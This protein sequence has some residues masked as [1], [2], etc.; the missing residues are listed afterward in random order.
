MHSPVRARGFTLIELLVG[1][2]VGAVVLLGISM[3]FI[4]QAQQYQSHASR[5]GIQA[6]A[7]QALAFMERK[8]RA[9]GYGVHPD[10]AVLAYDSY[11]VV[12]DTAAAGYPDAVVVH[13]R[14]P[15]FRRTVQAV[16]SAQITLPAANALTEPMRRGQILLLLCPLATEFAFVTVSTYLPAGSFN[17]PVDQLSPAAAPNSPTQGPGGLFREHALIDRPCFDMATVVKI[18]R[19]AFYVAIFDGDGDP[20]TDGRTPYLMMHQGLDMPSDLSAEG[21][22]VID[23]NDSVPVAEGIEQFQVAYVLNSNTPTF[24]PLIRGVNEDPLMGPQYYGETWQL[25][26]PAL[27]AYTQLHSK[28]WFFNSG[29]NAGHAFRRADHPANIRQVRLTVV[30]RSTVSDQQITGDNLLSAIEG[31]PLPDGIIPWRQLENLGVPATTD[32]SPSG[33]GFYRVL[34]RESITPKNLLMNAQFPPVSFVN[35]TAPGGG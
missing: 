9:A 13:S 35:A 23:A 10:R 27:T 1:A 12:T 24:Q 29:I 28:H 25:I 2:A 22:G 16:T 6:N 5:R 11:D 19:S 15:L 33:R 8:V 4:S 20:A 7:R 18:N 34:L 26:D 30:A 21:D 32:F 31:A 3:T 17:I 14:D